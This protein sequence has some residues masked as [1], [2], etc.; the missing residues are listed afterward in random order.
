MEVSLHTEVYNTTMNTNLVSSHMWLKREHQN[1][2]PEVA[3]KPVYIYYVFKNTET[4]IIR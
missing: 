4:S 1:T 2:F 3:T